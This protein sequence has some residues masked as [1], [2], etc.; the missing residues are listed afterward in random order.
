MQIDQGLLKYATARQA[1]YINAVNSTGSERAGA[2]QLGIARQTIQNQIQRLKEKAAREGYTPGRFCHEGVEPGFTTKRISTHIN[3]AGEQSGWH[4]QE[5]SKVEQAEA[6]RGFLEGLLQDVIPAPATPLHTLSDGREHITE[7]MTG[8]FIGDAHI[9]MRAYSKETRGRDFDTDIATAQLREAADYLVDKA[10]AT[11]YGVLFEVGDFTHQDNHNDTTTAGTRLDSDTRYSRVM[12]E[13]ALTM[14]YFIDKMLSKFQKVIVIIARG[15]HNDNSAVA[16][17]GMLHFYYSHDDRVIVIDNQS[18]YQYFEFGKWLFSVHHGHK[19][20]PEELVATM[21]RD[22][23]AAWGRTLYR[24]IVTGHYHRKSV[25]PLKGAEHR[26]FG[27]LTPPD[28]W[29]SSMGYGGHGEMEM[30]TFKKEG[31]IHSSHMFNSPAP[32]NEPDLVLI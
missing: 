12:M 30:I 29:H 10:E 19:Q 21:A 28:S 32:A 4:I 5:P 11:E 6:L 2:K 18:Y 14:R 17:R 26:V 20:K 9:G 13:A 27:A 22:M 24:M 16:I 3:A 15:N 25:T 31:G 23:A 1:E 8:I 7:L